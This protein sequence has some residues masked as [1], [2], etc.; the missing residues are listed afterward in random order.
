M[1]K[2]NHN[3]SSH[4]ASTG[5]SFSWPDDHHFSLTFFTR[6]NTSAEMIV[7]ITVTSFAFFALA[8][9][10]LPRPFSRPCFRPHVLPN[11]VADLSI[12]AA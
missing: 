1:I 3:S 10:Q 9:S 2:N 11:R 12:R 5:A 4:F 6:A 7:V 8:K